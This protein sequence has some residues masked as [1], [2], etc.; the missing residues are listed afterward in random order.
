MP[1]AAAFTKRL[2]IP[3]GCYEPDAGVQR[4]VPWLVGVKKLEAVAGSSQVPF[5]GCG[6]V[7]VFHE[8][9]L[10]Y[11]AAP[12]ETVGAGVDDG[13]LYEMLT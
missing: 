7:E 2:G 8:G 1:W 5:M 12:A 3:K 9:E 13:S 11:I 10:F 4:C 6:S